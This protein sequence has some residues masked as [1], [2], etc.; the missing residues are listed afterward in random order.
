MVEPNFEG[1]SK[2]SQIL[3]PRPV[4][5]DYS[6]RSNA[7]VSSTK[8]HRR[9]AIEI[10]SILYNSPGGF[11]INTSEQVDAISTKPI[12][13][14]SRRVLGE[15]FSVNQGSDPIVSTSY[16]TSIQIP[17]EDNLGSTKDSDVRD[18]QGSKHTRD[19]AFCAVELIRELSFSCHPKTYESV[20]RQ[21]TPTEGSHRNGPKQHE[22]ET[23]DAGEN[24]LPPPPFTPPP[25]PPFIRR[26][27]MNQFIDI[28][29]NRNRTRSTSISEMSDSY[30]NETRGDRAVEKSATSVMHMSTGSR[31]DHVTVEKNVLDL[32]PQPVSPCSISSSLSDDNIMT[33]NIVEFEIEDYD[34]EDLFSVQ[35]S[36]GL[37]SIQDDRCNSS[38]GD[39]A[40]LRKQELLKPRLTSE[41]LKEWDMLCEGTYYP[42]RCISSIFRARSCP[43]KGPAAPLPYQGGC[44]IDLQEDNRSVEE[45]GIHLISQSMFSYTN[46][47]A[48]SSTSSND[49]V[50][51][52]LDFDVGLFAPIH[53]QSP[54]V[55][56]S[57]ARRT[58]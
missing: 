35:K 52:D 24:D 42:K 34:Y 32:D 38:R 37:F 5:R 47:C 28:P 51:S 2:I 12:A 45:S 3:R 10:S 40:V 11:S 14:S 29:S 56:S 46:S 53:M 22:L 21:M 27:E 13:P 33:E 49:D 16:N 41:A 30:F 57:S 7:S 17:S 50:R 26:L 6:S 39:S 58:V 44:D 43:D 55:Q 4:A 31:E 48:S 15:N 18:G 36:T 20:S 9:L 54:V 8:T 19:P 1:D 23:V 25:L